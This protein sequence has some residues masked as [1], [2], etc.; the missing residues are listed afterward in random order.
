MSDLPI[1]QHTPGPWFVTRDMED[2]DF[3]AICTGA[4]DGPEWHGLARVVVRMSED[5][6]DLPEGV[7]NARLIAA[8][9]ELLDALRNARIALVA[10]ADAAL[11]EGFVELADIIDGQLV[12]ANAAID[13][14]TVPALQREEQS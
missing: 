12:S 7:A 1:S 4:R 9:P 2:D 11:D 5:V 8:A 3:A 10:V 6:L 13:K 14:A